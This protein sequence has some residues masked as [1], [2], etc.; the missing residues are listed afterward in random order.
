MATST[1][2]TVRAYLKG[3]LQTLAAASFGFDSGT[4]SVQETLLEHVEQIDP[5]RGAEYLKH[6]ASGVPRLRVIGLFVSS[7]DE[8]YGSRI[9]LKRTYFIRIRFY[10]LPEDVNTMTTHMEKF[11]ELFSLGTIDFTLGGLVENITFENPTEEPVLDERQEVGR[12]VYKDI[13][14]RGERVQPSY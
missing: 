12:F 7:N 1:S 13:V 9:L 3:K 10:Y 14:I 8:A 2:D 11:M 6:L 5:Y 4:G